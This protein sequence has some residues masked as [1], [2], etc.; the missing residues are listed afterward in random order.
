M[1]LDEGSIS[2]KGNLFCNM[3]QRKRKKKL[4]SIEWMLASK[5]NQVC[6]TG[7]NTIGSIFVSR[8]DQRDILCICGYN[9]GTI[10]WQQYSV[11]RHNY[12]E[13]L[14]VQPAHHRLTWCY[15]DSGACIQWR[16]KSVPNE[17][18]P[19]EPPVFL[20]TTDISTKSRNIV[21]K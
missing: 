19:N 16:H 6:I 8:I 18:V 21:S 12:C 13:Q 3:G 7:Y 14:S 9:F 17:T 1:A 15:I 20:I 5:T 10:L 4:T 11:W 2:L